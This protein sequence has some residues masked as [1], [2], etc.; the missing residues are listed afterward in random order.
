MGIFKNNCLDLIYALLLSIAI[1]LISALSNANAQV[2]G[3]YNGVN[4][5]ISSLAQTVGAVN[6]RRTQPEQPRPL[7]E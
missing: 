5:D 4:Y 2:T 7:F 1:V 3:N 6:L